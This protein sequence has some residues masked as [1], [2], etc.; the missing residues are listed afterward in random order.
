MKRFL[1][2]LKQSVPIML[3]YVPIAIAYASM[4]RQ[5]GLSFGET[6]SMSVFVY[7]GAGQMSAAGM[8]AKGI[9][10]FAIVMTVFIMNLRHIIM[11]T[12]VMEDLRHVPWWKRCILAFGITDEVFAVYTT[13]DQDRKGNATVFLG[14]MLG[15]WLSWIIGSVIG[16]E[17]AGILPPSLMASFGVALYAMFIALLM[18]ALRKLKKLWIP[19]VSAAVSGCLISQFVSAN[20]GLIAGSLIGACIGTFFVSEEDLS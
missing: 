16:Y 20:A 17:V 12:V 14:I 18:P 13:E 15:A 2:G 3:G 6:V 11:S 1:K 4:A 10:M 7:T 8:I 19:V 5:A 9:G